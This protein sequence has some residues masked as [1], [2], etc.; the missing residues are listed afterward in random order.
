M[1]GKIKINEKLKD[2]LTIVFVASLIGVLAGFGAYV[3]KKAIKLIYNLFWGNTESFLHIKDKFSFIY[4]ILVP[5]LGGLVVGIIMKYFGKEVKGHGMASVIES[6]FFK[7][8]F[9]RK[10]VGAL[11]II[12]AAFTI[13]TG[14]SVGKEDPV[15]QIGSSIGSFVGQIFKMSEKKMRTLVA[16]GAAAG[17]ASA[18]NAPL[19]GAMFAVEIILGDFGISGFMPIIVASVMGVVT[20]HYLEGNFSEF[21]LPHYQF[22]NPIE[23]INYFFLGIFAGILGVLFI[24]TLNSTEKWW[25]D[26]KTP[27]FLK[28]AMGGLLV[29]IMGFLVP[30]IFGQGFDTIGLSLNDKIGIGLLAAIIILKII[31]TSVT[32]GSGGVGGV[33]VPS[34]YIGAMAGL[35]TGKLSHFLFPHIVV[36]PG[37]YAIAGMGAGIAAATHAPITA[38]LLIFE[39]TKDYNVILP[40]MFASIISSTISSSIFDYSVYTLGLKLKGIILKDGHDVNLLSS[41][42]V[43]D[44]ITKDF[45]KL[46]KGTSLSTIMDTV[47]KSKEL[48]FHVV[49]ENDIYIGSFSLTQLKDVFQEQ[50][51]LGNLIIAEDLVYPLTT[52][53]EE[54]DL[55][56]VMEIFGS[57]EEDELPVV[58][59]RGRI[60]GVV[61]RRD[62][63]KVYNNEI[64]KREVTNRILSKLKFTPETGKIE[65]DKGYVI[66]E[67]PIPPHFID[68]TIAEL[69]LRNKY[70][71]EVLM[72]K[73]KPPEENIPFPPGNYK[74]KK[75]DSLVVSGKKESVENLE[76]IIKI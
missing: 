12:T 5:A 65:I 24:K 3:L 35:L 61:L 26:L 63:I 58:D 50:E 30:N 14:G 7:G 55:E 36:Y 76:K 74:F 29:G 56:R 42:K 49:D 15:I 68:K 62:V 4:I 9:I 39:L 22:H 27:E 10:R 13:G 18:F 70:G 59:E 38:I 21:I 17:L 16:C 51:S 75:D 71:I 32:V 34:M 1:L 72:I 60:I 11:K 28:P 8:G 2:N 57:T 54:D 40:L 25:Q 69:Q 45:A 19:A 33:F 48:F 46:Y 47:F 37:V 67:F 53:R 43:K 52:V 66:T 6:I 44:I 23:L 73:K 31:A 41:I 20:S 64:R